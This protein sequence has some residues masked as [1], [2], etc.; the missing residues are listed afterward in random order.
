MLHSTRLL[1][2]LAL[3]TGWVHA[4][5]SLLTLK[6]AQSLAV[7]SSV[8]VQDAQRDLQ[9]VEDELARRGA[10]P[11]ALGMDLLRLEHEKTTAELALEVAITTAESEAADA[12]FAVHE[13]QDQVE[14]ASL[15]QEMASTTLEATRIRQQAGTATTLDVARAESDLAT[16]NGDLASARS[17]LALARS[18]LVALTG[19]PPDELS[20]APLPEQVTVPE[21]EELSSSLES[22]LEIRA[23]RQEVELARAAVQA[24]DN[25]MNP[26]IEVEQARNEVE[27]ATSRLASL[28]R[29]SELRVQQSH[30]QALVAQR[31]YQSTVAAMRIA[32]EALRAQEA[33]YDAGLISELEVMEARLQ[34]LESGAAVREALHAFT[35][36]VLALE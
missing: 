11:L 3:L 15:Q 16:R 22:G 20:L 30:S 5:E 1:F 2:L 34:R 7:E 14:L 4:Q 28:R 23:A 13:A 36:S 25:A 35:R 31:A 33:R 12:F 32:E 6:E 17:T 9:A 18:Q 10:D 26:R 24:V 21:L 29:A 19:R 27:Q 8:A